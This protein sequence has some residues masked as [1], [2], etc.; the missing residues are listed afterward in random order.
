MNTTL[1]HEIEKFDFDFPLSEYSF[2]TRLAYENYWTEAFT[3]KAIEEYKKFMFLA[4]TSGVMVSPSEIVDIVWHQHLIFTE[5]Y[6]DFCKILGKQINH[7]PST[8]KK[9]ENEIFS[10]ARKRTKELYEQNFGEQPKEFWEHSSIDQIFDLKASK[11]NFQLS[12]IYGVLGIF[13]FT[14][15]NVLFL[16]KTFIAINNPYFLIVLI[17]LFVI[18]I[19]LL[20]IFNN[21]KLDDILNKIKGNFIIQNL[22]SNELVFMDYNQLKFVI[23]GYV[24][25]MIV[26]KNLKAGKNETIEFVDDDLETNDIIANIVLNTVKEHGSINYKLLLDNLLSKPILNC[27][28]RSVLSIKDVVEK[29]TSFMKLFIINL[30]VLGFFIS[31]AL[32]RIIIGLTRG[33]Q[34]ILLL[35]TTIIIVVISYIFLT[36]LKNKMTSSLIPNYYKK[37][38]IS[39]NKSAYSSWNWNYFLL[40]TSL[41]SVTFL[42]MAKNYMNVNNN[43]QYSSCGSSCSSCGSSCGS[44]CG[45][46]GGD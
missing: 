18:S 34:I 31:L 30:C 12:L 11:Y 40:G 7:I 15:F 29:S 23:H 41:L 4:A 27:V 28:S 3:K 33:K 44:G 1:W 24:N 35:V 16:R 46:C 5:S 20:N 38:I 10:L 37:Q 14:G 22:S 8:H 19:I 36:V 26:S 2:S 13:I 43:N 17:G 25:Y 9:E 39:K 42:E 6:S 45:G 32:S 21:K